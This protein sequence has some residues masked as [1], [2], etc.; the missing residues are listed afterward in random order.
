MHFIGGV[1]NAIVTDNLKSAVT[2][3]SKYEPLLNEAFADFAAHYSIAVLPTR[4]YKPRD[5]ALVE[6][7]VKI[8]YTRIYTKVRDQN[9]F[10]LDELNAAIGI[11]LEDHNNKLLQGRH[12]SRRSQFEEIERASLHSLPLFPYEP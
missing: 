9:Y 10:N 1:P 2:K 3:S 8:I 6:G 11:A 12:Y 4:A 5:K 7:A